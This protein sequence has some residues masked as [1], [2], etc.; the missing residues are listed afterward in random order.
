MTQDN[1][2]SVEE[3]AGDPDEFRL[4]EHKEMWFENTFEVPGAWEAH[5]GAIF[6]MI[7]G[8][9]RDGHVNIEHNIGD[10]ALAK[11]ILQQV[12]DSITDA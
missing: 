2:N 5:K 1:L 6:G 12:V 10:Q 11:R 9:S 4:D 3:N 7:I 8:I